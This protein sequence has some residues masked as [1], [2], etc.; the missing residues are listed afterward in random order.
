MEANG[1]WIEQVQFPASKLELIDTAADAGAP[2]DVIERLQQLDRER[3]ES[4]DDVENELGE[5]L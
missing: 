4:R 5:I 3:Y 2:Q 1:D